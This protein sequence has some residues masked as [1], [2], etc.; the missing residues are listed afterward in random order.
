MQA[1]LQIIEETL[2]SFGIPVK[3]VEKQQGPTVTQFGLKPGDVERRLPDG[4]INAT[5]FGKPSHGQMEGAAECWNSA[6]GEFWERR[7][8]PAPNDPHTN[9]MNVAAGLAK[10]GDLLVRRRLLRSSAAAEP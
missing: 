6:D 7:G 2:E 3:V 10:N 5:I 8:I 1:M 9:R 4:S